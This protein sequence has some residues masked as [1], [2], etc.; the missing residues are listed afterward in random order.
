MQLL[1]MSIENFRIF[2]GKHTFSFKEKKLIILR[3]SN[4]HGKSSF[5]DAIEWCLTGDIQRY[6]GSAERQKFNYT[7]HQ[8]L[9][10][11]NPSF[12]NLEPQAS[13]EIWIKKNEDNVFKIKRIYHARK[14]IQKPIYINDKGY[15]VR[16]GNQKIRE[17]LLNTFA[18]NGG[19]DQ[20]EVTK[21]EL[22]VLL[23]ST[24]FLSQDQLQAF[25]S[26]KKPQERYAILE[27]VLGIQKYGSEFQQYI[28]QVKEVLES[29]KITTSAAIESK[30]D[31]FKVQKSI[32][33][34]KEDLINKIGGET[35]ESILR[36]LE[37]L[38]NKINE[39]ETDMPKV[40]L[41]I[42]STSVQ[43]ALLEYRKQLQERVLKSEASHRLLQESET[44]LS[45]SD[46]YCQ[47]K[48]LEL[49]DELNNLNKKLTEYE[50]KKQ[51]AISKQS[52]F[53]SLIDYRIDYQST[54]LSLDAI[55]EE[56]EANKEAQEQL[57]KSPSLIKIIPLYKSLKEF[58]RAY[59]GQLDY[60]E[61][62]KK[63]LQVLEQEKKIVSMEEKLTEIKLKIDADSTFLVQT[64]NNVLRLTEE[65]IRI[66]KVLEGHE[67]NAIAQMIHNLQTHL[68]QKYD[69]HDSCPVCGTFFLDST[70][71]HAAVKFQL[72]DYNKKIDVNNVLFREITT[73]LNTAEIEK[74]DLTREISVLTRQREELI[75]ALSNE[76]VIMTSNRVKISVDIQKLNEGQ[77]RERKMKIE[78]FLKLNET[79]YTLC[80]S[81]EKLKAEAVPIITQ[82][83]ILS[84]TLDDLRR[85][86]GK[87]HR[88]LEANDA[89]EHRLQRLDVYLLR[90]K[91]VENNTTAKI[92]QS[93]TRLIE[94][95]NLKRRKEMKLIEILEFIP[96]FKIE[97]RKTQVDQLISRNNL[98]R[99]LDNELENQLIKIEAFLSQSNVITLKRELSGLT[100]ELKKEEEKSDYYNEMLNQLK[101]LEES[102]GKIQSELMNEYLE[103]HS[104]KIDDLFTQISPH[105]FFRHVHLIS[106]NG[107]LYIV[108]SDKKEQN[109]SQ[110]SS[111]ELENRFNA[112][113]TFSSAQSNVL[114]VCIFLALGLSQEWTPLQT[115]G[116][117]DPF[118]NLDDI[119]V[120]SFLDVLSQILLDKQVI[121]ST[122]DDKFASLIRLKS[123]LE[124][125]QIT[126][127]FLESYSKESISI[128]SD[129]LIK[130][131]INE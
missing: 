84:K 29:Q 89:I 82:I 59:D 114:A 111:E 121:I 74:G 96:G 118:Q 92:T 64:N 31:Q 76:E 61:Q 44:L 11:Q 93:N 57:I 105:A 99:N 94:I 102:H 75:K 35:E 45:L 32:V 116:I 13:V 101:Q 54:I 12:S 112:S 131:S 39:Y 30:K 46:E 10:S 21:V 14:K 58:Q 34:T 85:I 62:L 110:L 56:M 128:R 103:R 73:N 4:G 119:N 129:C 86:A 41:Q 42:L 47:N 126:E 98:L 48:L 33:D 8:S 77:A 63:Y 88:L 108:V 83:A 23:A 6:V 122:H 109:L 53:N 43:T 107:E 27:K 115:I 70:S 17:L 49:T 123:S 125:N 38:I 16:E 91:D 26:A 50:E 3:G 117:D 104:E 24:Q 15:A 60:L 25:I 97:E 40:Q 130:N 55:N 113:L 2:Y 28:K 78:D 95:K 9:L 127:I 51:F 69:E 5:F 90:L 18:Y 19:G 106:K 71:L 1:Q 52:E 79:P 80:L 100:F 67:N 87:H 72:E 81:L 66:E 68:L 22:P 20:K 7:V 36:E 37:I 120:F 124:N 65:K